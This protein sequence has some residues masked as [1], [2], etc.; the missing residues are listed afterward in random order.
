MFDAKRYATWIRARLDNGHAFYNIWEIKYSAHMRRK[1]L[2]DELLLKA[3]N[4]EEII[5]PLSS[6]EDGCKWLAFDI[7][8]KQKLDSV[9]TKNEQIIRRVKAEAE[10]QGFPALLERSSPWGCFHLWI[11]FK[12]PQQIER[13]VALGNHLTGRDR[14]EIMPRG[15]GDKPPYYCTTLRIPGRRRPGEPEVSAVWDDIGQVWFEWGTDQFLEVIERY[16]GIEYPQLPDAAVWPMPEDVI[17]N[18]THFAR[19]IGPPP[20]PPP[21]WGTGTNIAAW[22]KAARL[23]ERDLIKG[24]CGGSCKWWTDNLNIKGA[25]WCREQRLE[26]IEQI[27]TQAAKTKAMSKLKAGAVCIGKKF[28]AMLAGKEF[29]MT[30]PGVVD[31]AIATAAEEEKRRATG[32][33]RDS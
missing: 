11:L 27:E 25:D 19:P 26:I 9:A 30:I 21:D 1:G 8:N 32:S 14:L 10:S 16:Q 15:P 3:A 28:A 24:N 29:P 17:D 31:W 13:V 22:I 4:G 23:S 12:R 7:D 20:P 33:N 18:K 2:T 5:S 6:S